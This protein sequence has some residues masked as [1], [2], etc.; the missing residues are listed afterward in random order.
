MAVLSDETAEPDRLAVACRAGAHPE[1]WL[2]AHRLETL[3]S[4]LHRA[5]EVCRRA[6]LEPVV[7]PHAGG[8]IETDREI[9]AVCDRLDRSLV[10]LCLDTGHAFLGD[11]APIALLRDYRDLV[12][13]V[14]IKDVSPAVRRASREEALPMD[15]TWSRGIFCDLGHGAVPVA[16]FMADLLA[17]GYTGTVVVEKDLSPTSTAPLDAVSSSLRRDR[18]VL[19]SL[20]LARPAG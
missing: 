15:E 10:G 8:Y 3:I 9:R 5:A 7:H 18:D 1:T 20:G 4:N 12:R 2:S 17:S 19:A 14:H 13:Y 6:G 11:A 16:A